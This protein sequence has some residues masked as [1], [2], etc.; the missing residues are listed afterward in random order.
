MDVINLFFS[1]KKLAL[2]CIVSFLAGFLFIFIISYFNITISKDLASNLT[3]LVMGFTFVTVRVI[4]AIKY[5]S[6]DVDD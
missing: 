3:L 1:I 5:L 6:D 4:Q 2:P